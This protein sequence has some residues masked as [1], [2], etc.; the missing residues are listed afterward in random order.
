[1]NTFPE[2][3]VYTTVETAS[4]GVNAVC[5][6]EVRN[7][8]EKFKQNQPHKKEIGTLYTQTAKTL[9]NIDSY[10]KTCTAKMPK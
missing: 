9:P 5:S 2:A 10:K 4:E 7:K 8:V 1:M 6:Y 3:G